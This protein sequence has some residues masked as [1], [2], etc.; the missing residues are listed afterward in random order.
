VTVGYDLV[1]T[2]ICEKAKVL[3]LMKIPGIKRGCF[4]GPHPWLETEEL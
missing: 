2:G 1:V 4:I 3:R